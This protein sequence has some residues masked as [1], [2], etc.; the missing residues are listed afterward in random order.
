MSPVSDPN[1]QPDAQLLAAYFDG[2]LEGRDELADMRAR[3]EA[4]LEAHPEAADDWAQHRHLQKLW[5]DTVPA[6]PTEAAWDRTLDAIDARRRQPL[7]R[8]PWLAVGV[9]AACVALV[10]AFYFSVAHWMQPE[11]PK[12]Q[13]VV[14]APKDQPKPPAR[15]DDEVFPVASAHEVIVRRIEGA[16]TSLVAVARMPVEGVLE[17]AA[18]GDVRFSYV[19]PAAQ[20]NMMPT[21]RQEKH[22]PMV[23]MPFETEE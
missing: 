7:P 8:R 17:L 23:W 16:D 9:A 6:E 10:A 5:L 11:A 19:R 14:V 1:W 15:T 3:I 18:P 13:P 4:W 21:V 22:R 20:D 12:N 2:E